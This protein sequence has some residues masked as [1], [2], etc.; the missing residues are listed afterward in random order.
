MSY[1]Q[2][3]WGL[4]TYVHWQRKYWQFNKPLCWANL[5]ACLISYKI[6]RMQIQNKLRKW[7]GWC[8]GISRMK[9]LSHHRWELHACVAL[10]RGFPYPPV[11]SFL[12][13]HSCPKRLEQIINWSLL[14]TQHESINNLQS[15]TQRKS[16]GYTLY[17]WISSKECLPT[18]REREIERNYNYL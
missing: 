16:L 14:M 15:S 13:L 12:S 9:Q 1:N 18:L 11:A 8:Q 6:V 2:W 17:P 7:C 3:G 5:W 4:L 10:V